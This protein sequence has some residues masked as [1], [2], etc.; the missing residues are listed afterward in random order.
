M[1]W[2]ATLEG[3][4][5][6]RT[7][8]A[9]FGAVAAALAALA[10]PLHNKW[11]AWAGVLVFVAALAGLVIS[12]EQVRL[13]ARRE[14]AELDRRVRAPV[15]PITQMDP[16]LIGVDPAAQ[17]VLAGDTVPE[18]VEREVDTVLRSAIEAALIGAGRWLL[19]VVGG[20]KVGKSRTLFEALSACSVASNLQLI[21]PVHGD[22]LR[23]LLDPGQPITTR[24]ECA[25]LWLD[26]L[27]PFL[28]QGVTLQTLREWRS[29]GSGRIVAATYGGKG[30]ELVVDAAASGLTTLAGDVLQH[31]REIPMHATSS[32][33]LNLLRS[34]LARFRGREVST[35]GDGFLAMFDGPQRAIRCA[36]AIRDAVQ[37]LGIEVRAGLHT[38]ECEVRGDDIGG[39]AVHIGA[40]VSAVAG[41]ND[42][43]VSSATS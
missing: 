36:M 8:L 20:S 4:N 42:V 16:T 3:W 23:S 27:E 31:A 17:T 12:T 39:I 9:A 10:V 24:P 33:E 32:V 7:V 25:V 34:Q 13:E 6:R 29:G 18:Y 15:C 11:I 1:P 22:A 43:L 30:S 28:N 35:A 38:G 21:A 41:P 5:R 40:R 2:R 19:V 37:A 26:D 14:R